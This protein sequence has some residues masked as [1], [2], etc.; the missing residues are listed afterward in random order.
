[1]KKKDLCMYEVITS[2]LL[3]DEFMFL[4]EK[5]NTLSVIDS[6]T[7]KVTDTIKVGQRPREYF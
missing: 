7:N 2:S 3:A 5:D 6:N 4:N 1:M